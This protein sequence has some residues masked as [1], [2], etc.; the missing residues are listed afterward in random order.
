M[1][2]DSTDRRE[3]TSD[4]ETTAYRPVASD[5]ETDRRIEQALRQSAKPLETPSTAELDPRDRWQFT[6]SELVGLSIV[7]AVLLGAA[8][9]L[10]PPVGA[11]M[12]EMLRLYFAVV[13]HPLA[14]IDGENKNGIADETEK[15]ADER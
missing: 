9:L 15:A 4:D 2:D 6:L 14:R 7:L 8:R 10:S 3:Q 12:L 11:A 1:R 5:P 13:D